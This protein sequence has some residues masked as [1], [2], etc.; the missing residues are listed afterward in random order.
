MSTLSSSSSYSDVKAAYLDNMSYAE[1]ASVAKAR[2]FVTACSALLL[3]RPEDS[4]HG[5]GRTRFNMSQ[6]EREKLAAMRW[7]AVNDTARKPPAV[8]SASLE[9]YR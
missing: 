6:I 5:S 8:T 4:Q 3:F 2:A 9:A 7:L 1:D